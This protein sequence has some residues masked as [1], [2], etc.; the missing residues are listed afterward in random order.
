MEDEEVAIK[1]NIKLSLKVKFIIAVL[2]SIILS[3]LISGGIN[4][5]VD[6]FLLAEGTLGNWRTIVTS[7]INTATLVVVL[8]IVNQK[9]IISPLKKVIRRLIE[10]KKG[11]L[12]VSSIEI[13]REDE[14]GYL[15]KEVNEMNA[16]F[17]KIIGKLM[18]TIE[19]V[20]A[21][22][23]ELAA[24]AEEGNDSIDRANG[25][26][27]NISA[28]IEQ[29]SASSEEVAS[30]AEEANAQTDLGSEN[31]EKTVSS[32]TEIK[33][34]VDETVEAIT[35]L[36]NKSEEIGEIV[37]M[38]TNIAEQTNLLALNAAIEAARAGEHGQGFAVVAEEIRGLAEETNQATTKISSLVGEIQEET[39]EGLELINKTEE[40]AEVGKE[41]AKKTTGVF[42]SISNSSEQ[43]AEQ[44]EE[45]A[46]ATQDLAKDSEDLI[47][48]SEEIV[49]MTDEIA[50]SSIE[51]ANMGEDL[52]QIVN[53]FNL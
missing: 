38:I 35:D 13:K 31:I 18:D 17:S 50:D 2:A 44:V 5:V 51:L 46:K 28:G 8:M 25:L 29:V 15:Q 21:Y 53:Q 27:E 32:I 34:T 45:T 4:F 37:E 22:S 52:E 14:L 36:D 6:N 20:S 42:S 7:V 47:T 12:N 39:D 23:E 49:S 30:F 16:S 43:T 9:L 1:D 24:S 48:T 10:F 40:K 3:T 26:I 19:K 11:N 41:L 33:T